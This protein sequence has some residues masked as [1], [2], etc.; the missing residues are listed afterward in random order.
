[1]NLSDQVRG[2]WG[3]FLSW[4][5][6]IVA[7]L[8]VLLIGYIVARAL[9]ALVEGIL[10]K[11]HLNQRIFKY[12]E[13]GWIKRITDDPSRYT[14]GI[15]YWLVWIVVITI[16]IPI[17]NIPFLNQLIFQ[18]YA[19]IPKIITA[20]II[21][22]VAIALASGSSIFVSRAMGDTSTGK[23]VAT[24]MPSLIMTIAVFMILVQ[25][26]I[27]T[28]I[29]VITYA[30]LIGALALGFSLAFGL[31]G[32]DVAAKMLEDAYQRGRENWGRV[33]QDIQT[34]KERGEKMAEKAK[35]KMEK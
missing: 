34:G 16:A 18:F 26:G 24:I 23:V 11:A 13:S 7:T 3:T 31:G 1:M 6:S 12:R 29:V 2:V 22:G 25:L 9:K 35:E 28:S 14:G 15:V 21:L 33:R 5:P 19:Y 32:R 27:A 17:L 10:K 20:I 4:I 30:A 8:L